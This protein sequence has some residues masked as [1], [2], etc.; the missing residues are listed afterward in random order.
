MR[1]SSSD[2]HRDRLARRARAFR[3]FVPGMQPLEGR[4]LMAADVRLSRLAW[5]SA[6]NGLGPVEIDRS[7]GGS[8]AGDGGAISL[9]GVTYAQGLGVYGASDVQYALAGRY[10]RLKA[11]VG[12]DDAA[13]SSGSVVFQV[14]ADGAK[15]YDSGL[16]TGA[17][18]AIPIDV[19]VAGR[20]NLRLVVSNGG[21]GDASDLADWAD[22]RLVSPRALVG[23]DF[24]TP[25]LAAGTH[26]AAPVGS[27]WTFSAAS[28]LDGAGLAADGSAM[29]LGNPSAPSGGQA[30]FVRGAGSITQTTANLHAGR[31]KVSFKAAQR[32]PSAA[33]QDFK[34][35]I[36]GVEV[37]RFTPA[38]STYAAYATATFDAPA[39]VHS[40]AIVG[41]NSAGGDV[42]ALLD[43][44]SMERIDGSAVSFAT[45]AATQGDWK[46][47]YGEDGY[48]LAGDATSL[49]PYATVAIAGGWNV[50]W[51]TTSTSVRAL[52][53]AEVA[54]RIAA[55]FYNSAQFTMDVD[56]LDGR[57]H[58]VGLY[59]LD[60]NSSSRSQRIDVLDAGTGALLDS[61]TLSDFNGGVYATWEIAGHVRFRVTKLEGANAMIAGIFFDT[62]EPPDQPTGL[63]ASA[64][65]ANSTLVTW[66]ASPGAD[67]YSI[68][69][70]SDGTAWAAAGTAAAGATSFADAALSDDARYYY[71]VT[72]VNGAGASTSSAVV[73]ATTPLAAPTGVAAQFFA[74]NRI[75]VTW[76]DASGAESGY[77]VEQSTDGVAWTAVVT[78]PAGAAK[79]VV[80]GLFSASTPYY[81]R[82]RAY[83]NGTG[84]LSNYSAT[85]SATTPAI[86]APSGLAASWSSGTQVS[87]VWADNSS[88][89][90]G[91]R[92]ERSTDGETWTSVGSPP[93]GQTSLTA[94]GL[95]LGAT[96]QFRVRAYNGSGES[97]NSNVAVARVGSV[98]AA[99]LNLAA[100]PAGPDRINLA[101]TDAA[102]NETGYRIER[103][104][105]GVN[106]ALLTTVGANQTTSYA[107]NLAPGA[108]YHFRVRAYNAEN[109]A[110]SNVAS[111]TTTV[112]PPA[113][114]V[115][116]TATAASNSQVDLTWREFTDNETGYK[117]ERSTD[118]VNF[119]LLTTAPAYQSSYSATGLAPNTTYWFR[120]RATNASGDSANSNVASAAT[121]LLNPPTNLAATVVSGG[122]IDLSWY[123]AAT[124]ETGYKIERSTDGV[125]FAPLTTVG[126]NQT[127]YSATG[128]SSGTNYWFRIRSANA[129]GDSAY[130]AVVPTRTSTAPAAP[131]ALAAAPAAPTKI[132]LAWTDLA[133]NET[134]YKIERSTDGVNFTLLQSL[135][136]NSTTYVA[137]V[138]F[139]ATYYFR[140]RAANGDDSAPSNVVS[141]AGAPVVPAAPLG[142]AAVAV[143]GVQVNLTWRNDSDD[144]QGYRVERS[145]DGVAFTAVGTTTSTSFSV[146]GLSP[147]TAYW[148]RVKAYNAA[149]DSAS[150]AVAT[151]STTALLPAAPT[152]LTAV[153][154]SN[155]EVRLDWTDNSDNETRFD[156]ERS[157]DGVNFTAYGS[158]SADQT[159]V[160]YGYP[161]QPIASG[162]YFRIR[163]YNAQG[164]S[165]FAP[166]VLVTM[167]SFNYPT[168]LKA[169]ATSPT[170][171]QLTWSDNLPNETAY[172]IERSTD[173][174][175]FTQI[176]NWPTY[177]GLYYTDAATAA[178]TYTYRVRAV[179]PSGDTA[180]SP[181]ASV[182]TPAV[183]PVATPGTL[184]AS[185]A[186]STR[187]DLSWFDQSNN[188]TGFKVERSTDGVTFAEIGTSPVN[189]GSY[190]ATGLTPGVTYYFRVRGY[191]GQGHSAYSTTASAATKFVPAA[192]ANLTAVARGDG[193]INL[194]W[195]DA[196][197]NETGY[198]IERS[199]NGVDFANAGWVGGNQT[200][201]VATG[202]TAG[203]TYHFRVLSRN[204]GVEASDYSNVASAAAT[205]T[206]PGAPA[207]LS[208]TVMGSSRVDLK[209]ADLTDNETGYKV[210]RSTDGVT[211]AEIGPANSF[212]GWNFSDTSAAAGVTYAY[213]VRATNA[214]GDSA[215][216]GIA[217]AT[218]PLL[219]APT[220]LQ[221]SAASGAAINLTWYDAASNETGYK[222]ERS[223]DGVNFAEIGTTGANQAAYSAAGLAP[224]TVYWFRVRA[225][226]ASGQSAY[227]PAVA[228]RTS[229]APAA[230]IN[231]TA[232]PGS[233]T[234]I[235][236]AWTDVATNESGYKVERSTD[237]VD[238][239]VIA[240]PAANVTTAAVGG[241]TPGVLYYFR[242]RA[243]NGDDSAYS[244]VASA[245]PAQ[246][247]PVPPVNL[248]ATVASNVQVN[249]SW[250]DAT[251]NEDQYRVEYSTDGVAFTTAGTATASWT[252]VGSFQATNLTPGTTYWFRVAAT[253][254]AGSSTPAVVVATTA[255]QPVAPTGF[256][257]AGTSATEVRLTWNDV[258]GET[259]YKIERLVGSTWTQIGVVGPDATAFVDSG[260]TERTSYSYRI[261]A[262]NGAGDSAYAAT[263]GATTELSGPADLAATYVSAARIDLAWT[264]RSA[265]ETAYQ[266]EWSTNGV[267]G[268]N[269]IS[270]PANAT[271]ASIAGSFAPGTTYYFRVR[272]VLT[273]NVGFP[274]SYYSAYATASTTT[275]F[276]AAPTGVS[277]GSPTS[278][279]LRVAWADA[280]GT[281]GYRVERSPDGSTGWAQVGTAP[282]GSTSFD[283]AGLAEAKRYYYRVTA[284]NAGGDSA[285]SASANAATSIA[286]PTGLTAAALS[287]G[288]VDLAWTDA[289]TVETAYYL[290]RSTNGVSWTVLPSRPANSVAYSD[291]AD[292]DGSLTYQYRIR[293]YNTLADFSTYSN[294]ASVATASF[295][296]KPAAP[297]ATPGAEGSIALTWS[298][299][300][301]AAGYRVERSATGTSGW[302]QVGAPTSSTSLT[303]SGLAEGTRYYYRVTAYNA[304]GDSAPGAAANAVSPLLAPSGFSA[305]AVSGGRVDLSWT[306]RSSK[307]TSY[308]V[309]RS[310]DGITGW[311]SVGGSIGANATSAVDAGPFD[312][313]TTYHYRIRAYLNTL[314]A[315]SNAATTTAATPAFPSKPAAPTA[316]PGAEGSI[317]LTWSAAIG[318]AGYRVERS[319]TGTSGW[320]QVGAPTSSTSLTDSGLAEGTRYY[321][322]VTAYNAAGDSAPGAAANAVSPL[323]APSGFSATAVSGGRVD[324]SW[325]DRSS[326][327]TSY[328]VE[329]S[330]DGITGW[331]SVGGSIGANATS[332]V[333]AG[334]FDGST[335]YHY[336]IRAYLNTLAAYSNAA[337]TTAAT[338]A[339]PSKPAAPTATP[340]AEGSIALTWSAAI[341]AAG[342][343]V[344]RS[345]TGTS[346][347]AQV[348]APTSS[349][350]LTDSGL[351]EGTRYYYRVTAYNAAGDS[352]PGAAANAVSPL[353]APSGFSATAVSGGRVDLSWTDR[354]SKETS[355]VVERS[356]DG[357]TGW[358]SVGGSIGANATSAVDAG[359]FDG[360]TTYHYRIRAYL[361]T[362]AA[363]SNAATTTAATP[364]FPSK[365][366]GLAATTQSDASIRLSWAG[367]VGATQYRI[368]RRSGATWLEVTTVGAGTTTTTDAGLI[369]GTSYTYRVVATNAIGESA[370]S[371]PVTAITQPSAPTGLTASIISWGRADIAWTNNSSR[372]SEYQVEQSNDGTT[373][374]PVGSVPGRF[375][376]ITATGPFEGSKTYY[377]RVRAF[378]AISGHSNYATGW[379][380]APAFPK[381]PSGVKAV[382]ASSSSITVSWD[383][384]SNETGYRIERL[385]NSGVWAN[386]GNTGAGATSFT[387]TGLQ[388][389]IPYNYRLIAANAA[390]DSPFSDV[391]SL[392][393]IHPTANNESY[394][395]LHDR[396]LSITKAYGVLSNDTDPYGIP[397]T[398][399]IVGNASHG[400]V[401]LN[402]DGSF[403]YTPN[404]GFTGTDAFTYRASNGALDSDLATVTILVTNPHAP[405]SLNDAYSTTQGNSLV[406]SAASSGILSNDSDA[407]GDQLTAMLVVASRAGTLTLNHDGTFTYVPATGF[408][409][410]DS[411]VYKASD[412][413]ASGPWTTVTITVTPTSTPD[414]YAATP[415]IVSPASA[416]GAQVAGESTQLS[417]GAQVAGAGSALTYS[418]SIESMPAG[419][420]MPKFSDNHSHTAS[421]VTAT[422]SSAGEYT[423]LVT[424]SNQGAVAQ[425]KAT[426][427]VEQKA[428]KLVLSSERGVI[429]PGE[430]SQL[431][432]VA[433]DQFGNDL[434]SQPSISWSLASGIGSV[435]ASGLYTAPNTGSGTAVARATAGDAAGTI[436]LVI[437][438]GSTYGEAVLSG[439]T[440]T[441]GKVGRTEHESQPGSYHGVSI[442]L[443]PSDTY[444]FTFD[445]D[446]STW[447][448][449]NAT[450]GYWDSFSFSVTSKPFPNMNI[451][452][453]LPL[454]FVW[455]GSNWGDGVLAKSSGTRTITFAGDPGA[456]NYLNVVLDT[457]TNSA[458]DDAFPS[459]GTVTF[460]AV[461]GFVDL[462]AHR[463]GDN[464]GVEVSDQ[465]EKDGDPSKYVILVDNQYTL[466]DGTPALGADTADIPGASSG[467]GDLDLA[468]ITIDKLPAGM[469]GGKLKIVLSDPTAV[470]L[471]KTD[472]SLFYDKDGT[473]DGVLT[474]DLSNPT[475]YLS[476][477]Q[478]G[479]LDLWLQGVRSVPKFGFAVIYQ[480]EAGKVVATDDI[481]MTIAD[482]NFVG[483][484][485]R[486]IGKLVPIWAQEL[487]D[488]IQSGYSGSPSWS[489]SHSLFKSLITG[490]PESLGKQLRVRSSDNP[491]ATY[492][493]EL[494]V[495]A[496]GFVSKM[497]QSIY[498][499][500]SAAGGDP[501]DDLTASQRA[502]VLAML[503]VN[504]VQAPAAEATLELG[505]GPAP[506]D[507]FTR[508][509]TVPG[510]VAFTLDHAD[511]IYETGD[512]V[513][514]TADI[515]D[516][517][518]TAVVVASVE[519]SD[520][521]I[522]RGTK[523]AG[524]ANRYEFAF[525]VQDLPGV[526]GVSPARVV[527]YMT[528][529]LLVR[530]LLTSSGPGAMT[531]LRQSVTIAVLP[532]GK[533]FQ[534]WQLQAWKVL[535]PDGYVTGDPLE[536]SALITQYYVDAF[537]RSLGRP[538]LNF[539]DPKLGQSVTALEWAGV[540]TFASRSASKAISLSRT[541]QPVE[542]IAGL[543][544]YPDATRALNALGQGNITIFMD[545]YPQILAFL[546]EGVV[547]TDRLYNSGLGEQY[548]GVTVTARDA[549]RD[550][551]DGLA[552]KNSDVFW[553]GQ[554]R[555]ALAEQVEVLQPIINIDGLA[556]WKNVTQ[557][558]RDPIFGFIM[559]PVPGWDFTIRSPL[560]GDN[561]TFQGL[562]PNSSFGD[563][564]NRYA[565]FN[566]HLVDR[567]K[568]WRKANPTKLDLQKVYSGGYD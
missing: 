231:L 253:N 236:L 553:R 471:F 312:G 164:T 469:T 435:S 326:K 458:A 477:I 503:S 472:G 216:S 414:D 152:G 153:P 74:T 336:R 224:G 212:G 252:G 245:A 313:S 131:I 466:S 416:S 426:V 39:G 11:T 182:T 347:W 218:T 135:S 2:R 430:R 474:L 373:W 332:A 275:A 432:A 283:D 94:T 378:S 229:T 318:A 41:L 305:T 301:G 154:L 290:E 526:A 242:V 71:R 256:A 195:T 521:R 475:G 230:P 165:A 246:V 234:L 299:A 77:V 536:R 374:L 222:V 547:G 128:L 481:Q 555:L 437:E 232:A 27:Q 176:V 171:V 184:Y 342:Y 251:D 227:S 239:A 493:D 220:N 65:S 392:T 29:T 281:S 383:D 53:K 270:R 488:A 327:E 393:I 260:L 33:A 263:A 478:N 255:G 438:Y 337:T 512:I 423:F 552:N 93:A 47:T 278:S 518:P 183:A 363:Y 322:R 116:L 411:F 558:G 439:D 431:K 303:D 333:D 406:I 519:L 485:G 186:S 120:V 162:T 57:T 23:G 269:L 244:N 562:F 289:S 377:F 14:W 146:T 7:N 291:L 211:F 89:E 412:G 159:S 228:G 61:R 214:A 36:D 451:S 108:A 179:T 105:D 405:T 460:H 351:A 345:A 277:V 259:G 507:K 173:G 323:L 15:L 468:K 364:A 86:A 489:P 40:L 102:T 9:D 279:S 297:T 315:Y 421:S 455:G 544:N 551:S 308:V 368:E 26:A 189:Q 523:V 338:P 143:S 133:T 292:F 190:Q 119:T 548:V 389:G 452:D 404:P 540:A 124:N 434:K 296:S 330:P 97:A 380:A 156:V 12:I 92:V 298:A 341:G 409:G 549:W 127:S 194:A 123:D 178:T 30:A 203:V 210:E 67:S 132:N 81:F 372:A 321:Y 427:S 370:P 158:P 331:T 491:A 445:Y 324:L 56:L 508:K 32:S 249:L 215:Y 365:P 226:S 394:T 205:V 410:Q 542:P 72:A 307:E 58:R 443:M 560:P 118:G 266:V 467:E 379:S 522:I 366:T 356:P 531:Y 546:A 207:V 213:R 147:T 509:L 415:V 440:I 223:A 138:T 101:W 480:D 70:S 535:K 193:Y 420:F 8:A 422:F 204:T 504:L 148:F 484:D 140:V 3:G 441:L 166:A 449:Y 413:V 513:T 84:S 112:Q 454:P 456:M 262:T 403:S 520:G 150:S 476:G 285:P 343:R 151:A 516:Y 21:D 90:T 196:A 486:P 433:K 137:T 64:T 286:A 59:A 18:A 565:F 310:P 50:T 399:A 306:D 209:W 271:T 524:G 103:S 208:A 31:Y 407:D 175:N 294:V 295:P 483:Y 134:G 554:G 75:D 397:L 129:S 10:S 24:A 6:T 502:A 202:L 429:R 530:V 248:T 349:T 267:T 418:W 247:L 442:L 100:V 257:A 348:G 398:A 163:A 273:F 38:G 559:P 168:N 568:T 149:G 320:A 329:R 302:A 453:P 191:N 95:T 461:S 111:A 114:P 514:L 288:R 19:D 113:A 35:T 261:R 181:T 501:L 187:I 482:W 1:R 68:E 243:Y 369:E 155:S 62:L 386:V 87:L 287:G 241:L 206:P 396:D 177:M 499:I 390:G 450:R 457:G 314:A 237:G 550:I 16:V 340:G 381:A 139:G 44:V 145:T 352:A 325:T 464:Q 334:P 272:S 37:G 144:V 496:S 4:Q 561:T 238:F 408:Y 141:A 355:Y 317:A 462:T 557:S 371:S 49:P 335:T 309:E 470:R 34:V 293:A 424:V 357:I 473:G 126:A 117:V 25:Q 122:R 55:T 197:T 537:N 130:S 444:T 109:S 82:V 465:V 304:A 45:D 463:T 217:W 384:V 125:A 498:T 160:V 362:L 157:F 51:S 511:S 99:P 339:F 448:S 66:A 300:I 447:D 20:T 479:P 517:G 350:S 395:S 268:W 401:V 280:A 91:F 96:Y 515:P 428:T 566:L 235:N 319:A 60:W 106:F 199:T 42:A 543:M 525:Q 83:S 170:Q 115:V 567:W 545:I 76:T 142:L 22:A 28:G 104:T 361:N 367:V 375:A 459:W 5:T 563:G 80:S 254:A 539:V 161:S 358:T 532:A 79:A 417:V 274:V 185:P 387:D 233:P 136:A 258:A 110:W 174:V 52:Q 276:P 533:Q 316:T 354:S 17:S 13:G 311:T 240:T 46:G 376:T 88:N 497:F 353:L 564:Y 385:M 219:N 200:S 85:A 528:S 121:L 527:N 192:P 54:G 490:L 556:F 436:A 506:T 529:T 48:R 494:L 201:Y 500:D 388:S 172:K 188:E 344:E 265:I 107:S 169:V 402:P 359:P 425:S 492:V 382:A 400:S 495:A 69:R 221:A 505:D 360:S 541:L 328:V 538:D 73:S 225:Y 167:P 391:V 510:Q 284:Y 43:D 180:F 282:A 78:A 419:A 487:L 446:F 198:Y 250:T 534:P 63:S 98:P 264:D 346:G